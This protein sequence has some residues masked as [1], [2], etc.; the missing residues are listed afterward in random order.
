ML[1]HLKTAIKLG[2]GPR[3]KLRLL[4]HLVDDAE[5][6]I[7]A[8]EHNIAQ[9]NK[10]V[11]ERMRLLDRHN[12][13]SNKLTEQV[14]Y[15]NTTLSALATVLCTT[16]PDGYQSLVVKAPTG[17]K[18]WRLNDTLSNA[19]SQVCYYGHVHVAYFPD[20][21]PSTAI[22]DEINQLG[23]RIGY[24]WQLIRKDGDS[25]ATVPV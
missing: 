23:Q 11:A 24:D 16:P 6:K 2:G 17:S 10:D 8:L 13:V 19:L 20:G 22:S 9:H 15:I 14:A 25:Y 1:E 12:D 3:D 7:K 21:T 18:I 4:T 5:S